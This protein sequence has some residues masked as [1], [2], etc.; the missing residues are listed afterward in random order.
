MQVRIH[1]TRLGGETDIY[2]EGLV[3]D[4]GTRL[5]T[6]TV[7]PPDVSAQ[8]SQRYRRNGLIAQEQSIRSLS[9]NHFYDEYFSV[10]ELRD[11][12]GDLLGYYCDI[13]TPLQKTGGEYFI[14]D[15]F[16]DLWIAP[17]GSMREFDWDELEDAFRKG[18][19]SSEL[20]EKAVSV[21]ERLKAETAEG[22][23]PAKH[24][25]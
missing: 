20:K 25:L 11:R 5:K 22:I 1:Y 4:N 17:D 19:I 14:S 18:L 12:A 2:T 23:F 13:T 16:L 15:L 8:L 9:K 21:F 24:V 6:L 3:E 10:M 7:L